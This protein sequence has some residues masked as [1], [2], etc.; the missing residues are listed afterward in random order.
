MTLRLEKLR[1]GQQHFTVKAEQVKFQ[2]CEVIL[3]DR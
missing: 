2:Q 3:S 1:K